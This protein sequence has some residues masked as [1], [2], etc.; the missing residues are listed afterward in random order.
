M[1]TDKFASQ[2][3]TKNIGRSKSKFSLFYFVKLSS[4]STVQLAR[5][6]ILTFLN[7]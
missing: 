5:N 2:M 4:D 6:V 3:Q 1:V 7:M